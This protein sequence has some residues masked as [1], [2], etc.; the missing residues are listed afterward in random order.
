MAFVPQR[1]T[2]RLVFEDP[3]YN[4]L[5]VVTYAGTVAQYLDIAKLADIDLTPPYTSD[6]LEPVYPLFDAFDSVLVK[7]NIEQPKGKKVP[8]TAAGLKSLE[9]PLA[10]AIVNAWMTAV[11]GSVPLDA[12]DL[13]LPV[14]PLAS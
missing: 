7:W 12:S 5:E 1:T 2:Y 11:A 4:G 3:E 9:L 14:E 13:D 10:M 6:L 8:A